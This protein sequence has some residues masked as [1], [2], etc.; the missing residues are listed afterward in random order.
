MQS[1]SLLPLDRH[2]HETEF[3]GPVF[4]LVGMQPDKILRLRKR[5]VWQRRQQGL[6]VS[7]CGAV[8]GL[9][10]VEIELPLRLR[11]G[12]GFSVLRYEL[13][14]G[15]IGHSGHSFL[16]VGC[17]CNWRSAR[18]SVATSRT[19]NLAIGESCP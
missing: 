18:K 9:E 10:A 1:V 15:V 4:L 19:S 5:A 6:D 14:L 17:S 11:D 13:E 7:Q 8:F 12:H 3:G 16:V 2:V